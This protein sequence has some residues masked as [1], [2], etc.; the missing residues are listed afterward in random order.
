MSILK[1]FRESEQEEST[2]LN[3][4]CE[5]LLTIKQFCSKF[6]WPSASALRA[7]IHRSKELGLQNAFIRAGRRVLII[8]TRFF[9][10][11]KNNESR[12]TKG[13]DNHETTEK[14]RGAY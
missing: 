2:S 4:N 3:S 8:P 6:P 10:I 14:K 12:L 5:Q 7:Y 13:G 9:S 1:T 11:I